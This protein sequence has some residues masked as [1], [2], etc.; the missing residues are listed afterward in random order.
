MEE[1]QISR[2]WN[3]VQGFF[4]RKRTKSILIYGVE[5][6]DKRP[7]PPLDCDCCSAA[8]GKYGSSRGNTSWDISTLQIWFVRIFAFVIILLI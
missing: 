4:L 3:V 6:I 7:T 8:A 1:I 5:R 2:I